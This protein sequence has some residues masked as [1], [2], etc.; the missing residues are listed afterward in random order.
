MHYFTYY[1]LVL[2]LNS[3]DTHMVLET[4]AFSEELMK[5]RNEDIICGFFYC[6]VVNTEKHKTTWRGCLNNLGLVIGI[7]S[8]AIQKELKRYVWHIFLLLYVAKF[9]TGDTRWYVRIVYQNY[10]NY[11]GLSE[12]YGLKHQN[13]IFLAGQSPSGQDRSILPARVAN[14]SARFGSFCRSRS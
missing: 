13:M 8:P 2:F 3:H 12:L 9:Q 7:W 14:H 1:C 11:M 6:W 5:V 10:M 4:V